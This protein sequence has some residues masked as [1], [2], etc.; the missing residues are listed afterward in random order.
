VTAHRPKD[1]AQEI[2][3]TVWRSAHRYDPERGAGA[4][5]LCA[6]ARSVVID[7]VRGR[8]EAG[9]GV[10]EVVSEEPEP[11]AVAEADVRAFCVRAAVSELP[12]GEREVLVL[13]YWRGR[14]QS[15]IADAPRI[16]LGTVKTRTRTGLRRSAES[17]EGEL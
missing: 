7:C 1:V 6:I 8:R 5:W 17:L 9:A 10:P 14:S 12:A 16:P 2:F 4:P 13:A 11:A 15:E 3:A